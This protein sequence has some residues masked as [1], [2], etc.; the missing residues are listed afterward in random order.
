MTGVHLHYG[1]V[2][3]VWAY[4]QGQ[5]GEEVVGAMVVVK[6]AELVLVGARRCFFVMLPDG[7]THAQGSDSQ[8]WPFKWMDTLGLMLPRA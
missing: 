7:C 2:L 5:I 3:V 4:S 6:R 8:G 1:R